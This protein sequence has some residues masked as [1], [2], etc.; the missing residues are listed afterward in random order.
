M[1]IKIEK[2]RT[3]IR[4][5]MH[6]TWI[7]DDFSS[8]F[9]SFIHFYL[10]HIEC[11]CID[12]YHRN[13]IDFLNKYACRITTYTAYIHIIYIYTYHSKI[14]AIIMLIM[15]IFI[16]KQMKANRLDM[17]SLHYSIEIIPSIE[18]KIHFN[19]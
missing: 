9:F 13:K 11:Y 14:H 19:G 2:N 5:S 17:I 3:I 18:M 4:H 7:L 1:K 10:F 15:Y 12:F 8:F 6:C 16:M